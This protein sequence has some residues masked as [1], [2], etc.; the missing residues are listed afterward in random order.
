MPYPGIL[1]DG[2][3]FTSYSPSTIINER[4]RKENHLKSDREYRSYLQNNATK[5]MSYNFE[6]TGKS[7]DRNIPYTFNPNDTNRPLG[8]ET[9]LPK[10]L[11][12]SREQLESNMTR[13]MRPNYN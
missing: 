5:I 11:Y 1:E 13:P 9:S 7:L 8:Y 6:T 12:L 2:R 4:I 10:E 3:L